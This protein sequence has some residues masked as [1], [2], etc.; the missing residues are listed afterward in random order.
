MVNFRTNILVIRF[1]DNIS[2]NNGVWVAADEVK[3]TAK[4]CWN[5]AGFGEGVARTVWW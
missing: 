5:M 2:V 4:K 3:L 1:S